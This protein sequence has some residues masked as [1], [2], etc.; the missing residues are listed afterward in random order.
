M[1]LMNNNIG[2][3]VSMKLIVFYIF[4]I[5][6]MNVMMLYGSILIFWGV[7]WNNDLKGRELKYLYLLRMECFYFLVFVCGII[8]E[9]YII[10]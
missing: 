2:V 9:W 4:N 6:L 5:F 8:L 1:F 10:M 7:E 3:L